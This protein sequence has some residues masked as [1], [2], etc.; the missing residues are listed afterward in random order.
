MSSAF[1]LRLAAYRLHRGGVVAYPTEAIYGLG[2]DPLNRRAVARLLDIKQRPLS[3]GLILV[4]AGFEQ[5]VPFIEP[6]PE[7]RMQAVLESWPG[8]NTWL[9]P[10][11]N[12]TPRWL[13][14]GRDNIAVRVTA[15]S[16]AAD[17]CR[18]FGG[19]IVSTSANRSGYAP[20]KTALEVRLRC[21]GTDIVLHGSTGDNTQPTTIR[22]A[23]TGE[24]IRP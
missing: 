21:P 18:A 2:C 17:L 6:L 19:A 5:L 15:H 10:A 22:N 9:L 23:L 8:P 12:T 4:A 1:Q 11:A 20:A 3:K 7:E 13:T 14:G 24:V 16:L